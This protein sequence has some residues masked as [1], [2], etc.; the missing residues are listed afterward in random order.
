MASTKQ[1]EAGFSLVEV[2]VSIVVLSVGLLG[3]IGMQLASVRTS[4]EAATFTAALNLAREL[5]EK[6][7]MNKGVATKNDGANAYLVD[8]WRAGMSANETRAGA[9]CVAT[10]RACSPA[11]IAAWDMREWKRRIT[12]VLP[13]ARVSVCFDQAPWNEATAEYAWTCSNS[14][15]TLVV[16]LGWTPRAAGDVIDTAGALPPPRLVVQLVAGQA[17]DGQAGS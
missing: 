5:S 16:K 10:G 12:K 14:G 17:H 7:R 3:A 11:D 13:D 8:D 1:R 2:L 15:R 6:A 9:A 4:N